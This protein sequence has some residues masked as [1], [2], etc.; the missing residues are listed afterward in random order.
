MGQQWRAAVEV[1]VINGSL[2]C[3]KRQAWGKGSSGGKGA[4][5]RERRMSRESSKWSS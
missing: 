2:M 1:W 3:G 4:S 5:D